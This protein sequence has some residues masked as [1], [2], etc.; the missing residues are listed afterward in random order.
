MRVDAAEPDDTVTVGGLK[1]HCAPGGTFEQLSAT[2]CGDPA[3]ELTVTLKLRA[4][5]GSTDC[6]LAEIVRLKLGS[7]S[8]VESPLSRTS[9]LLPEF[10]SHTA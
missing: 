5:P 9:A 1:E 10:P 3:V 8:A 4:D 2:F 7:G 6:E